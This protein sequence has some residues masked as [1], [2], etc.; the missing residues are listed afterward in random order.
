M[1]SLSVRP[2]LRL[3]NTERDVRKMKKGKDIGIVRISPGFTSED[4][5][6]SRIQTVFPGG[7][8]FVPVTKGFGLEMSELEDAVRQAHAQ[9]VAILR[10]E[11][12]GP[13]LRTAGDL[14]TLFALIEN[15]GVELHILEPAIVIGPKNPLPYQTA[16]TLWDELR[17]NRKKEIANASRA[18]AIARGHSPGRK[19]K[20]NPSVVM[21]LRAQ[22]KS[23]REIAT[24][25]GISTKL[26]QR[27]IHN[28]D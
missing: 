26:V 7:L 22:G 1:Q 12:L 3:R 4:A 19:T 10:L 18:K 6:R 16:K 11:V 28:S 20:G 17:I 8:E 13:F 23:I 27:I 15:L 14:F 21:A 5:Q 9:R 25:A 24:K 2:P